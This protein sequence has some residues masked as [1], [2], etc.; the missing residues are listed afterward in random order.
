MLGDLKK[1]TN[2]SILVLVIVVWLFP[3]SS[4]AQNLQ[5][6]QI[7]AQRTLSNPALI[8]TGAINDM[9]SARV[10][11][12][13][14][15][16]WLGLGKRLF[17]QSI[18]Y[19]L[20]LPKTNASLAAGVYTTDFISGSEGKS[21][22]AHLS[23]NLGYAYDLKLNKNLFLK[24]GLMIQFSSLNFGTERFN[25]EDQI[26]ATNTGFLLPTE[27]PI[28]QLT[29]TAFHASTGLMLYGTKGYFG[30]S[31]FNLNQPDIS[32]FQEGGQKIPLIFNLLA[33]YEVYE[34]N[35]GTKIIPSINY[36]V[37]PQNQSRGFQLNINRD[38]FRAG[39][40]YQNTV[41]LGRQANAFNYYFGARYDHVYIAYSN[42]WNLSVANSGLPLTHEISIVIFTQ[43]VE[44]QRRPNPFP[45]M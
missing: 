44:P 13:T 5:F 45:E 15:A 40:G 2:A 11:S 25:W 42:D 4:S 16:Q 17:S 14:R 1:P 19:D 36:Y 33:G 23:G 6:R 18:S 22:Y 10:A 9:Q 20:N 43:P 29:K 27:E 7:F 26:N 3:C 12:G 24:A 28:T 34:S 39:I 41:S 30:L 21:K 35:S 31:A 37:L 38:N 32:F 8:G